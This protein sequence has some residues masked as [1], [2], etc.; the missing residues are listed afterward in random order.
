MGLLPSQNTEEHAFWAYLNQFLQQVHNPLLLIGDFNE[1]LLHQDKLGGAP[2]KSNQLQPVPHLLQTQSAIDI[3]CHKK[4]FSWKFLFNDTPIYE[5]LDT[6]ML[7]AQFYD[8][9]NR[10][11]LLYWQFYDFGPYAHFV[12]N[13]S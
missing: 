9:F 13:K 2:I 10:S 8:D 3:P 6:A 7:N 1:M 12:L 5:G 11:M 4:A